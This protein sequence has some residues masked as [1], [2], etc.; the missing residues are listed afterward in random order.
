M[1]VLL[2]ELNSL[3]SGVSD[4]IMNKVKADLKMKILLT[5]QNQ[6]SRLEEMAKNYLTYG[7]ITMHKYCDML[8]SVSSSDV[9]RV[10]ESVLQ[11]KPTIVVT[12]D[13]INLVPTI[14]DVSKQ[15]K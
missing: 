5:M 11:G 8:D 6:E 4:E 9:Q 14:T 7:D 3:K 1:N 12:G 15:L 10:A 13:A 2:D